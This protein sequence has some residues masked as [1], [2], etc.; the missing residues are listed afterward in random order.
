MIKKSLITKYK[1]NFIIQNLILFRLKKRILFFQQ[2]IFGSYSGS[3]PFFIAFCLNCCFCLSLSSLSFKIRVGKVSYNDSIL[4]C[5]YDMIWLKIYSM[6]IISKILCFL[7]T[8][9]TYSGSK[10]N[11]MA[12]CLFC[13]LCLSLNSLVY[14]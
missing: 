7:M 5:I 3:R 6:N 9:M 8:R 14:S 12:F 2:H 13:C 11:L 4:K 1:G 10:P